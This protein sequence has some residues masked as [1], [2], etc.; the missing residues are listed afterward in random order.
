MLRTTGK[1]P[2][3]LHQN[4]V[5]QDKGS[6]GLSI[7]RIILIKTPTINDADFYIITSDKNILFSPGFVCEFVCEQDNS[8]SYGQILMKFSGYV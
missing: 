3:V 7:S 6:N 1:Y 2:F 5:N 8:E 4:L